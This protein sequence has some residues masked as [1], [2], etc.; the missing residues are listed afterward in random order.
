MTTLVL[1]F[2]HPEVAFMRWILFAPVFKVLGIT[3]L[4]VS[5][6]FYLVTT[7]S[8]SLD[9]QCTRLLA[10]PVGVS[11]TFHRKWANPLLMHW[12]DASFEVSTTWR[13]LSGYAQVIGS[14][15]GET[16]LFHE[17]GSEGGSIVGRWDRGSNTLSFFAGSLDASEVTALCTVL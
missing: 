1:S 6:W 17:A 14:G 15:M 4:C 7:P 13:Y 2:R 16:L 3:A 9:L 5:G 12:Q 11:I 8:R 10:P